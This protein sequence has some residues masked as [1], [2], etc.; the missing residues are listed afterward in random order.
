[1][2][3]TRNDILHIHPLHIDSQSMSHYPTYY[4]INAHF[5]TLLFSPKSLFGNIELNY[6]NTGICSEFLIVVLFVCF[7]PVSIALYN[8]SKD[9][10]KKQVWMV[11]PLAW[12]EEIWDF[13]IFW[14]VTSSN[15][16]RLVDLDKY[17]FSLVRSE[18]Q[19]L[20]MPIHRS[21]S[22]QV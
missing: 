7:K 22:Y 6:L 10:I 5:L 19:I 11:V 18:M 15:I 9:E 12:T 20:T 8:S 13:S 16:I 1:M 4:R 2:C 17:L 14:S 3:P 21:I